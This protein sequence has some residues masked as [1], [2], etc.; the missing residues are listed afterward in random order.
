MNYKTMVIDIHGMYKLDAMLLLEDT[1]EDIPLEEKVEIEVV[2]G[3]RGGEVLLNM[4]RKE[5]KHKR[6]KKRIIS[7]NKGITILVIE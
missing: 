6:I 2:H 1:I 4:V 5:L 7:M 3:Y